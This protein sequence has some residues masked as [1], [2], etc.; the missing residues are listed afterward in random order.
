MIQNA[1][2]APGFR[3]DI[4]GLRAWAV[5]AVTFYHFGIPGFRGGFVGVDVFFVISGFLMTGIV[6]SALERGGFSLFA[7]Y[8]ARAR[9]IFPALMVL[10]A[11]L[12]ALGWWVLLPVEYKKLGTQAVFSLAFLSN[13]KFWLEAGYFDAASH[14]KWLLH[15]WSLAVEW[16]FYLLL[17]LVLLVMWKWRLGRRPL[18][19]VMAAGLLAS[20][21]LTVAATSLRPTAAFYLLPT[22]AWEMLAGGLAYLL[23]NRWALTA[24]QRTA[25]EAAGIA[26]VMGSFA[27]FDASSPWPGW[28]ALVPV[29]GAAA[30]LLAAR[31]V[32]AWTGNPFAQW[33]GTRSYSL[34]LWHWPIVVALTYLEWRDDS[35]AIAAGLILTLILGDLSYR[36]VETPARVHLGRLRMGWG[37]MALLG[38]AVA[39]AAPGVGV[40]VK[41]GV[42]GRFS[43]EIER[44]QQ[45]AL[46]INPRRNEC[47]VATGSVSPSCMHGGSRLGAIVMGD[48]HANSL[49]SAV[50]ANAQDAGMGVMEWSYSGCPTLEKVTSRWPE[51]NCGGYN[52]WMM[53]QLK[54]VPRDIP[55]V[56]VNLHGL[57]AIGENGSPKLINGP[58][59][60]LS[61]PYLNSEPEFLKEYANAISQMACRLA[62]DHR[63][64][65]VRPI[66]EMGVEVPKAMSRA[67]LFGQHKEISVS[68]ADYHQRNAFIWAAQDAARDQCGVK[69]LDP[70]PY[71]CPD[72]RCLGVKNGRPLYYD[73]NH[74]SEYGNKLLVP[75]FAEVFEA[76]KSAGTPDLNNAR[77]KNQPDF[78]R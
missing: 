9:R 74:L 45:G 65:L 28:R 70:L 57:Y 24:R 72:G 22:R 39:V 15:T 71:L 60:Y 19:V 76:S 66:P 4:N 37:A 11:V 50:T 52:E 48:S 68:L 44:M 17:P 3:S 36:L 46:D 61:R 14:E 30:V 53:Q 47:W 49:V 56:M 12:L 5:A 69:I 2:T 10:C 64:Y 27:G 13:I 31:S 40:R 1:S 63:V 78:L 20:L 41:E 18:I 59:V 26:L 43:P 33:L 38:T 25:L 42:P 62:K 58:W 23:A 29:L 21:A 32:S 7:F 77:V 75:M 34:Y 51:R 16:Q 67:M 55:L 35:K 73:E 6:V 8:L 54:N